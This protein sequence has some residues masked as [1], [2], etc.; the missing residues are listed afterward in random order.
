MLYYKIKTFLIKILFMKM[1]TT[2]SSILIVL[3][4][5]LNQKIYA[6]VRTEKVFTVAKNQLPFT[7]RN[8][9]PAS[10]VYLSS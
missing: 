8:F 1:G 2:Y 6:G 5:A 7:L 10:L 9:N 3:L 4:F